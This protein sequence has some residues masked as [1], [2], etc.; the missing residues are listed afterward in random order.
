MRRSKTFKNSFYSITQT[1]VISFTTFILF[2]LMVSKAGLNETGVWSFLSSITAIT[3]F[4]SFGFANAMLYYI[5]ALNSAG[6]LHK[7]NTLINTSFFSTAI[8]TSLLCIV[9]YLLFFFIIPYTV[10]KPTITTAYKL[11]PVI[12]I[13]FFFLAFHQLFCPF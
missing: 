9:G 11:L 10:D 8:F 12:V 7:I 2:K 13:S 1:V 6:K 5:P 3:S 4:G